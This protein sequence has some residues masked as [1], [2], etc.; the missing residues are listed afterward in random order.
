MTTVK[1]MQ[2]FSTAL[3]ADAHS[4]PLVAT[5]LNTLTSNGNP[6]GL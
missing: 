3:L 2:C 1:V 4:Q 5:N 6:G